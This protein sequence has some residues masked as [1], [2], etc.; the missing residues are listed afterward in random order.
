MPIEKGELDVVAVHP[1]SSVP[2][3]DDP[4][5]APVGSDGKHHHLQN[6][7]VADGSLFPSSIGVPPQLSIYAMGLHVGRSLAA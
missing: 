3:G 7:W 1:M 5:R 2:M 6:L 4:Q